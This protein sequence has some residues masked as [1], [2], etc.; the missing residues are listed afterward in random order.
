MIIFGTK[1]TKMVQVIEDH[2]FAHAQLVYQHMNQHTWFGSKLHDVHRSIA[3]HAFAS[4][5]DKHLQEKAHSYKRSTKKVRS[6]LLPMRHV[7]MLSQSCI[8]N[9]QSS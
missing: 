1:C 4:G 9:L 3:C 2:K 7:D 5:S 6:L 8:S